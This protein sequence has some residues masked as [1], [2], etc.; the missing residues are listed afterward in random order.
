[1]MSRDGANIFLASLFW[2]TEVKKTAINQEVEDG[3]GR[4]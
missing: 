4:N 1:M 3:E 2:N